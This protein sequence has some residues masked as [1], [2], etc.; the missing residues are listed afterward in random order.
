[1]SGGTIQ[2]WRWRLLLSQRD[3]RR[4]TVGFETG[5]EGVQGLV[6]GAKVAGVPDPVTD[7]LE[8]IRS[9]RG[10]DVHVV[11][12][13]RR[14]KIFD[15]EVR[16]LLLALLE[17]SYQRNGTSPSPMAWRSESRSIASSSCASF[18]SCSS[19]ACLLATS[20]WSSTCSESGSC[21]FFV[22]LGSS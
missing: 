9:R 3:R 19:C 16:V 15:N 13:Y 20:G 18:M 12:W 21:S 22:Y 7:L 5:E 17:V 11:L 2:A 4:H 1:M 8:L 6:D 10:G 14:E